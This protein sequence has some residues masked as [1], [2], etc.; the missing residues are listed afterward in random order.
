MLKKN[1][2]PDIKVIT[3]EY[4]AHEQKMIAERITIL[5]NNK[6]YEELELDTGIS[7]RQL[8]RLN[9]C[10]ANVSLYTWCLIKAL[11]TNLGPQPNP[12]GDKDKA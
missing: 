6:L 4:F 12:N 7:V 2:P 10:S 11:M 3:D 5:K 1:I 8:K 9:S